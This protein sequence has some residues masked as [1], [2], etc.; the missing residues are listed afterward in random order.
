M[1]KIIFSIAFVAASVFAADFSNMSDLAV[2]DS[3]KSGDV[4][5]FAE[6]GFELSKRVSLE[7]KDAQNACL[8]FGNMIKKELD[9]KTPE[10]KRAFRN[11]FDMYFY[12]NFENL[13]K[14]ERDN[15]DR[16]ACYKYS[17]GPK[18]A[19]K[20]CGCQK[21]DFQKGMMSKPCMAKGVKTPC[22]INHDKGCGMDKNRNDNKKM[23]KE[24]NPNCPFNK[25]LEDNKSKNE[26][27]KQNLK[28]SQGMNQGR[29]MMKFNSDLEDGKCQ[30]NLPCDKEDK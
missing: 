1:K 6:A 21:S 30:V 8:V 19:N 14:V 24:K 29:S 18:K 22:G 11:E 13:S 5:S 16:K 10:Q 15:F 2:V 20:N 4:K 17:K 25:N 3:V 7:N 26:D 12:A 9:G 27:F 23:C 28:M